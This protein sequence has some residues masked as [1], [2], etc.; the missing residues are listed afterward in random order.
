M[1][2]FAA[3]F[4]GFLLTS[5]ALAQ[6]G[7]SGCV[8]P[9]EMNRIVSANKFIAPTTA[10]VT[11]RRN[12]ANADVV[13]AE[14]CKRGSGFVYVIIALKKDG[15]ALQVLVNPESGKVIETQ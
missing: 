1:H 2:W 14:L 11:A 4:T 6:G 12:V 3:L 8:P 10:V 9:K 15:R 13:R 5:P 7:L